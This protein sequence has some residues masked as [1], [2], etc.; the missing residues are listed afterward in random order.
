LVPHLDDEMNPDAI[1][2]NCDAT[3]KLSLLMRFTE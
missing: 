2:G 1:D 3:T